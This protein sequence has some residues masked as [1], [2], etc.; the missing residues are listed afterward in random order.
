MFTM[1]FYLACIAAGALA[2]CCWGY[3]HPGKAWLF[4]VFVVL[5]LHLVRRV[6]SWWE[7]ERRIG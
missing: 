1:L 3:E 4:V 2:G 6:C 5:V 7:E